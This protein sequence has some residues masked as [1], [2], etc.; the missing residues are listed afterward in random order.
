MSK[1]M[2][3]WA[4]LAIA[5]L[6]LAACGTPAYTSEHLHAEDSDHAAAD[7][8]DEGAADDHS[9]E[10]ATEDSHGED[11]DAQAV[12]E[13]HTESDTA[14]DSA[15]PSDEHSASEES[16]AETAS[17][18]PV[19]DPAAGEELFNT[20][21]NEA[22]FACATCH[23]VDSEEQLVGPG[24]LNVSVHGPAHVEGLTAAEYIYQSITDPNAYVVEGYPE[25][26]MPQVYSELFTEEQ[27][28]DLVAYVLTLHD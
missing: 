10:A 13:T 28:W 1:L 8:H 11:T 4:V 23:R 17:Q 7:T 25:N 15:S 5:V 21:Y 6:L 2:R 12:E 9:E 20:F 18:T 16:A 24:L 19:G 3:L 26:L 14:T 22:G 27:I